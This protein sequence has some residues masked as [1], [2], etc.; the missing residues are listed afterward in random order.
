ME[1]SKSLVLEKTPRTRGKTGVLF[2]T[3][4]L[5]QAMS[6]A[7]RVS[8]HDTHR[9]GTAKGKKD[10]GDGKGDRLKGSDSKRHHVAM[11]L[12]KWQW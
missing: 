2:V 12:R 6:G 7:S 10:S 4:M 5:G 3:L 9:G 11:T 8:Q 1:G